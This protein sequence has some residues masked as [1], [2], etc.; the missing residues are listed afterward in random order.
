MST[1][2]TPKPANALAIWHSSL[3]VAQ[4]KKL[5]TD[6]LTKAPRDLRKNFR[7]ALRDPGQLQLVTLT[8]LRAEY[9]L[10]V[11]LNG[12]IMRPVPATRILPLA[13]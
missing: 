3:S 7:V 2:G 13:A 10:S 9:G 4:Q 11:S 12:V 5:N 6:L 1:L 8:F